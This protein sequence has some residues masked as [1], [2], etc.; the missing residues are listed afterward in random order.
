MDYLVRTRRCGFVEGGMTLGVGFEV[1]KAIPGPV[2]PFVLRIRCK[3]SEK[4]K[5]YL[6][7]VQLLQYLV[8]RPTLVLPAMMVMNLISENTS[9]PPAKCLF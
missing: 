9:K 2:S 3:L 4:V 6:F 7:K 5:L 8:C 1:S